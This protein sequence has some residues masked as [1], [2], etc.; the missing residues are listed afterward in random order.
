MR[1]RPGSEADCPGGSDQR[2]ASPK[3]VVSQVNSLKHKCLIGEGRRVRS[4]RRE[5]GPVARSRADRTVGLAG[6]G[7]GE[8][9]ATGGAVAAYTP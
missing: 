1:P 9:A 4:P 6:G 5:A 7:G 2:K 3:G 8:E